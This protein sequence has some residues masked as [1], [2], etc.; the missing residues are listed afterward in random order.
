[1]SQGPEFQV[2]SRTAMSC[3]GRLL[4]VSVGKEFSDSKIGTSL[5]A[6]TSIEAFLLVTD[7]DRVFLI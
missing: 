1:M 7:N 2:P 4:A 5:K 3:H 6:H